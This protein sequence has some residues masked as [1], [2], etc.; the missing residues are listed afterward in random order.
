MMKNF[1][2][3]FNNNGMTLI[4]LIV[5]IT[6][7]AVLTSIIVPSYL[8]YVFKSKRVVDAQNAMEIA[9]TMN[10]LAVTQPELTT[11]ING[12]FMVAIMWNKDTKMGNGTDIYSEM[13]RQMGTVPV[14]KTNKNYFWYMTFAEDPDNPGYCEVGGIYLKEY[15]NSRMGYELYPNSDGFVNKKEMVKIP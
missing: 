10:M 4:E 7:I 6:I 13:F 9:K 1:N 11:N 8:K 5:A 14:S 12:Q 3:N 15:P 2:K